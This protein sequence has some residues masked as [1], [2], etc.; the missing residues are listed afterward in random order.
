[1]TTSPG[2]MVSGDVP[3]ILLS[4]SQ[5]VALGMHYLSSGKNFIHRDLEAK[6]IFVTRDDICKVAT[7]SIILC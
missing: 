6:N 1:M 3:S 7:S 2:Q 5:Q 4:Y